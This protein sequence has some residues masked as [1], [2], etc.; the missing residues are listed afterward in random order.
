MDLEEKIE[1][2]INGVIEKIEQ[3]ME[4]HEDY[5][6]YKQFIGK[7]V[8]VKTSENNGEY[9]ILFDVDKKSLMF[10][11]VRYSDSNIINIVVHVPIN[12]I[13]LFIVDSD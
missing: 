3:K 10:K 6:Y 7:I 9:G 5:E 1:R 12:K 13:I 4:A 8:D 2:K 11:K